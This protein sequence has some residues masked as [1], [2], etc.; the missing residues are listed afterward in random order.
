MEREEEEEEEREDSYLH[1]RQLVYKSSPERRKRGNT[2]QKTKRTSKMQPQLIHAQSKPAPTQRA[3]QRQFIRTKPQTDAADRG[4]EDEQETEREKKNVQD[5]ERQTE[6]SE[7]EKDL[8]GPGQRRSHRYDKGHFN[9]SV[10]SFKCH[11]NIFLTHKN[12]KINVL[13]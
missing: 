10:T 13:L 3:R 7:Q 4:E 5:Q 1:P 2:K 11:S 6:T 9:D 12:Q 8:A